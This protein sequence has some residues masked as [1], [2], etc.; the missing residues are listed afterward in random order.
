MQEPF[1]QGQG[2]EVAVAFGMSQR[3]V[4]EE[5]P[6]TFRSVVTI[7]G[8]QTGDT[9]QEGRSGQATKYQDRISA[10]ET[11]RFKLFAL[12]VNDRDLGQG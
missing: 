1:F 11:G 12:G 3:L 6:H 9:L 8:L 2:I 7:D 4:D 5:E 10:L